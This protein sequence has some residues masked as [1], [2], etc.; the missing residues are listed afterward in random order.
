MILYRITLFYGEGGAKP[1]KVLYRTSKRIALQDARTVW[2]IRR[3]NQ[4]LR[5]KVQRITFK[6]VPPKKLV[7]AILNAD[8]ENRTF[9][10]EILDS[11]EMVTIWR[12]P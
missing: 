3:T 2:K 5:I 6:E 10:I 1:H 4:I 12:S 7:M 11:R 9:P 8:H